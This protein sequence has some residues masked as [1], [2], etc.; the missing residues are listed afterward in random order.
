MFDFTDNDVLEVYQQLKGKYDLVL[1]RT[2]LLDEGFTIDCPIII[3]KAHGQIIELYA[4]ENMFIIDVL[5]DEQT[6]CT[7]WHPYSI[8]AAA[9][10]IADFMN[11][12]SDYPLERLSQ[13]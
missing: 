4:C 10:D 1:T 12:K 2:S 8:D 5:N 13:K 6:M 7:H 9:E 3:G 11:G